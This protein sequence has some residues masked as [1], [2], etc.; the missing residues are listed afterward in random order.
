MRSD[1]GPASLTAGGRARNPRVFVGRKTKRPEERETANVLKSKRA[2]IALTI[3]T[4]LLVPVT[5]PAGTHDKL[6]E[7]EEQREALHEK[8]EGHEA[9]ADTLQAEAKALN[10]QM[11]ELRHALAALDRDISKIES[12]VRNAQ[13]R[14]DETQTEIDKVEGVATKQAVGLYKAGATETL[15]ALLGAKSLA[16]LDDRV[17]FLGIAAHE[18]TDALIEHNRLQLEIQA[19]HAALFKTKSD[20]EATRNEQGRLYASMDEKHGELKTKLARLEELLGH[21]HAEEG[22][23]LAAAAEIKGDIRAADAIRAVTARGVST[24]GFIWPL[25]GA[26]NSYY[27]PRWGRMHTGIDIDGVTGDPIVASKEGQVILAQYY[28]GY[29]NAVIVDHGGGVTTLYAHLSKFEVSSGQSIPQG[30]IVGLVG[31]T[32]SCTGDHLHFEVRINGNPV[33]PLDYLP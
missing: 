30:Q 8:I 32:G 20:L 15:D 14:I 17:E 26:I 28:S 31:C 24:E 3:L 13:A 5:A 6:R 19:Q 10:E 25:N 7:L 1:R 29:G 16:E 2:W 27:G 18:N 21:E 9:E 22:D 23:L 33:D 12:E 4:T 11:I